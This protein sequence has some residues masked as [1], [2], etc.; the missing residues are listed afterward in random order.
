[1]N[2]T[3]TKTARRFPARAQ[4]STNPFEKHRPL[5]P[6]DYPLVEI[7]P[8][9]TIDGHWLYLHPNPDGAETPPRFLPKGESIP[10]TCAMMIRSYLMRSTPPTG[11]EPAKQPR[12]FTI[13]NLN[14]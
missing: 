13:K 12:V 10:Q 5:T 1:M 6:E 2:S 7:V 11:P 3:T 9:Y 4:V 14:E 8:D